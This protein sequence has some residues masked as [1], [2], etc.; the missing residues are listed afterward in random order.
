MSV[1]RKRSY[2][3]SF[4]AFGFSSIVNN[5]V[6][7]PQCVVCKK[8]LANES[9]KPFKLKEHLTKVHPELAN[10]ELAYFKIKEDQLKRLRLDHSTGVL[11]QDSKMV[12][13]SYN[14]VSKKQ[15][16]HSH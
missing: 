6:Q 13:A 1:P 4:L 3:E 12:E 16:Q 8:T 2:N 7:L 9:M 11:F 10:K 15:V 14:I 5:G